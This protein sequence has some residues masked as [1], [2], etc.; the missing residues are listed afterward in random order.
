MTEKTTRC[1]RV[2]YSHD[3][4]SG[5]IKR[6]TIQ[7]MLGHHAICIGEGSKL[8]VDNCILTN[9]Q[10]IGTKFPRIFQNKKIFIGATCVNIYGNNTHPKLLSSQI[11][12]SS[13]HGIFVGE[14]SAADIIDCN[15]K[16]T[17]KYFLVTH[18]GVTKNK[19]I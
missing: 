15:I 4:Y 5:I 1:Q 13:K 10:S 3:Y 8:I 11:I 19:N 16:N 2:E 6:I 12:D 7:H 14:E 17:S 9:S 18:M